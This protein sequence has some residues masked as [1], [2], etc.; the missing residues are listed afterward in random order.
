MA[1]KTQ[2]PCSDEHRKKISATMTGRPKSKEIRQ[3]IKDSCGA[4]KLKV[5][6][7]SF[8]FVGIFDSIGECSESLGLITTH[9]SACLRGKRSSHGGYTFRY[10]EGENNE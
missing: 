2:P 1:K 6:N 9:I 10:A 5:F 7:S 4:R 3:K 8:E